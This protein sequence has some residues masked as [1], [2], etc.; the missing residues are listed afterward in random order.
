MH[1]RIIESVDINQSLIV[2]CVFNAVYISSHL[3]PVSCDKSTA[4]LCNRGVSGIYMVIGALL[5]GCGISLAW[6]VKDKY[7]KHCGD[8][9]SV[10]KCRNV[11]Y[12]ILGIGMLTAYIF[13]WALLVNT[14]L[15]T[16]LYIIITILAV[17]AI[18]LAISKS[19]TNS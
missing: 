16:A 10:S 14:K 11:F 15:R 9:D 3:I 8:E 18:P 19:P 17:S 13:V 2:F 4:G 7:L 6:F 5:G 12:F 1:E